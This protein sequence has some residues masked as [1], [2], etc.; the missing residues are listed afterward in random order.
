M[1][2]IQ[3][4]NKYA[5][6]IFELAKEENELEA[7]GEQLTQVSQVVAA[8][9]DLKAFINNPQVQPL[10]KKELLSKLFKEDLASSVYNFIM[11]LVDKRRESLLEEIAGRYQALSNAARN[12]VEAEVTVT[13]E[14]SDAQKK[15]L[16]AKLEKV[17]GKKVLIS[18]HIDKSIIG[19]LVVKMGDKL[20]DGSVV[21]QM[22]SLQKQLMAN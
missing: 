20:I 10:A 6:A 18:T 17:T 8:Q 13:S 9:A 16:I 11:L 12:I 3:L 1:L 21:S 4:A 7:Y 2:N 22:K 15:S 14:L 19:G 5:V